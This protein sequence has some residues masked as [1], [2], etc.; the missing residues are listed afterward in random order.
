MDAAVVQASEFELR[1]IAGGNAAVPK[2]DGDPPSVRTLYL[3]H[4]K[5]L[6]LGPPVMTLPRQL[7]DLYWKS[8]IHSTIYMAKCQSST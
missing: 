5:N 7:P 3:C 2:V 6:L 1:M 4:D 8:D